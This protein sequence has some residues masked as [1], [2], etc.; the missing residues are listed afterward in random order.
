MRRFRSEI[1]SRDELANNPREILLIGMSNYT[2][3]KE[4]NK[5]VRDKRYLGNESWQ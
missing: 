2:S 4:K 1:L 5:I 3:A